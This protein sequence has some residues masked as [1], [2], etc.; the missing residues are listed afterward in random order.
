V[1]TASIGSPWLRR[2]VKGVQGQSYR[3]VQHV[4]VADGPASTVR[5]CSALEGL[6][7]ARPTV[8]NLPWNSGGTIHKGNR[9]YA[10]MP[11]LLDADVIAL[12]D[13]DNV[14]APDHIAR[15]VAALEGGGADWG[16]SLRWI[17]DKTLS[18][19]FQDDCES[20]GGWPRYLNRYA[21]LLTSGSM[22]AGFLRDRPH[23]ADTSTL[24][25]RREIATGLIPAWLN[26]RAAD[27]VVTTQ[28]LSE[29]RGVTSGAYSVNY[30][31]PDAR[32]D[33]YEAYYR[34]ANAAL[35]GIVGRP[36]PWRA[37]VGE[38]FRE[39]PCAADRLETLRRLR[40]LPPVPD[41]PTPTSRHFTPDALARPLASIG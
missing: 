22:F 36:A 23:L 40:S 11:L 5:V 20:I 18:R 2:C 24:F 13:D 33:L 14:F 35:A 15:A 8:V 26:P 4:V 39:L 10:A 28:L 31:V 17:G 21:P 41:L 37:G 6:E 29:A 9:I 16:H 34:H 3:A 12:L 38:A 27:A 7:G 19:T 25:F 30:T 1:V 32:W